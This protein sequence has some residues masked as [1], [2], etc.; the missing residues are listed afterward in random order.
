MAYVHS[1]R[2]NADQRFIAFD[3]QNRLLAHFDPDRMFKASAAGADKVLA[4]TADLRD[5]VVKEAM[6]VFAR[7]G[8]YQ[9]A[10]LNVAGS[11]Y[12]ATVAHQ[13]GADGGGFFVLYAAPISDFMGPLAH[14]A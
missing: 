8:P 12:L 5:P 1:V 2:S 7:D 13:V 11:E 6:K 14:A 10:S 9:L 4:T 3:D